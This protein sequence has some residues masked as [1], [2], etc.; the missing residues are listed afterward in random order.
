[1]LKALQTLL[2]DDIIKEKEMGLMFMGTQQQLTT[3]QAE[4]LIM[5]SEIEE[6]DSLHPGNIPD[7]GIKEILEGS[8]IMS[9]EK[10]CQLANILTYYG[11]LHNGDELTIDGK[12]YVE[13]FKEY[14]IQK[15]EDINIMHSTYSLL[16]I[17]K[18]EFNLEVCLGKISILENL[19]EISDLLK[20][21]VQAIK[22]GKR[23]Q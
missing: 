15:S 6:F 8:N 23:N 17:E 20:N 21:V 3:E 13:L 10:F 4:L 14:L 18:L 12:Q 1:M 9:S 22:R 7:G 16:N 19:G 2:K 5:I 11:Y